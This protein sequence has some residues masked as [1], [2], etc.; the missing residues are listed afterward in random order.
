MTLPQF[1]D[2][3]VRVQTA[4]QPDGE[5]L[6][7]AFVWRAR[8]YTIVDHGRRWDAL[9]EGVRWHCYL[10]RSAA[11]ETFELCCADDTGRWVLRRAWLRAEP[12]A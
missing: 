12:S 8:V 10:V 2:E 11:G 7:V 3:P 1:I 9:S 4:I 6:P 5:M